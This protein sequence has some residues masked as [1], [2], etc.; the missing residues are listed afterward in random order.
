MNG[1]CVIGLVLR[2]VCRGKSGV[3]GLA[4]IYSAILGIDIGVDF[5][6]RGHLEAFYGLIGVYLRKSAGKGVCLGGRIIE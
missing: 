5:D 4:G 3:F 6:I 1:L 2:S